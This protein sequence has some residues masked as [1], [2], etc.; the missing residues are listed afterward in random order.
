MNDKIIAVLLIV[1]IIISLTSMI[2]TMGLNTK[3]IPL[4]RTTTI[5]KKADVSSS[6]VGLVIEKTNENS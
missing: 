3:N 5:I 2:V 6:N 1:A 4:E